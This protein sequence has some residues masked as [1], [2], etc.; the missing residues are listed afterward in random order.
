MQSPG[1][2]EIIPCGEDARTLISPV[3]SGSITPGTTISPLSALE[4]LP[5]R[6]PPVSE[7]RG[8]FKSVRIGCTHI[9]GVNIALAVAQRSNPA[10]PFV[11]LLGLLEDNE[12]WPIVES[13]PYI[14]V[15]PRGDGPQIPFFVWP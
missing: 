1:V 9:S 6:I 4:P 13:P 8:P 10:L 14:C 3:K 15:G 5:N 2:I 11:A 7:G 12:S